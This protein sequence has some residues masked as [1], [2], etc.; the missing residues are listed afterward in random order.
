VGAKRRV[1]QGCDKRKGESGDRSM[2]EGKGTH[3]NPMHHLGF[4]LALR[5]QYE[6]LE[7]RVGAGGDA[8][9]KGRVSELPRRKDGQNTSKI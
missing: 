4:V 3:L 9:T 2:G 5:L 6:H 8:G 7:D 1:E